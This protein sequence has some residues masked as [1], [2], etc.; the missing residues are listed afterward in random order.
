M[1]NYTIVNLPVT[2]PQHLS[3]FRKKANRG[4]KRKIMANKKG[5]RLVNRRSPFL[6]FIDSFRHFLLGGSQTVRKI[7]ENGFTLKQKKKTVTDLL[8]K[9]VIKL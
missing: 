4:Q 2:D 1:L 7:S 3:R 6:R 5:L 8:L 9:V